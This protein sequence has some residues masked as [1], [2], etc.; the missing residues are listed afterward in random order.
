MAGVLLTANRKLI[1]LMKSFVIKNLRAR[2]V[3]HNFVR[4][5]QFTLTGR[6][7]NKH[8]EVIRLSPQGALKGRVLISLINEPLLQSAGKHISHDHTHD[9]EAVQI[10]QTWLDLGY[11][12]DVVRW[13]NWSFLPDRD[14]DVCIDARCNLERFAPYLSP[15]CVKV[16]HIDTCHWKHHNESQFAR[17]AALE[18]RRGVV[19]APQRLVDENRGIEEADCATYLGN[20]HTAGTFAF[21]GKPLYRVPISS[22]D[23][24]DWPEDKDFEACRRRFLWFGSGGL[25]LKGLDLTLEAFAQMP[26]FHLT[27][28]GPV[29][30]EEAFESAYKKELYETPNIETLGW[31]DIHSDRWDELRRS[32]AGVVF[33]SCSEGGGGSVITCVHAGM[34][35]IV[36]AEASVDIDPFGVLIQEGTVESVITAVKEAAALSAKELETRTRA[37]WKYM[38]SN[39]SRERFAEEYTKVA[40]RILDRRRD[41]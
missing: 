11:A 37:G 18:D 25:I 24:Y 34:L 10:V 27:V 2:P 30:G 4:K 22:T 15:R 1:A 29:S 7:R 6:G 16:M 36:T 9:W 41:L 12:V 19:L 33:P 28:C 3:L 21:A 14:Y 39:H 13:T 31:V 32:C 26:E 20:A 8:Y 5:I 35:P 17:L 23:F 40:Q 38:R